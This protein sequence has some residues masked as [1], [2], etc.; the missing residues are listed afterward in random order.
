VHALLIGYDTGDSAKAKLLKGAYTR[1]VGRTPP[2]VGHMVRMLYDE[3][4]AE[5][6]RFVGKLEEGESGMRIGKVLICVQISSTGSL[7]LKVD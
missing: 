2:T 1:G 6:S 4:R 7:N 3:M 5:V